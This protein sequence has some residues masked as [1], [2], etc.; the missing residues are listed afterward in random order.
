MWFP[1]FD[2]IAANAQPIK[3]MALI[4]ILSFCVAIHFR[5]LFVPICV[6]CR[7]L[8]LSCFCLF[9]LNPVR[10]SFSRNCGACNYLSGVIHNTFSLFTFHDRIITM[11]CSLPLFTCTG[12]YPVLVCLFYGVILIT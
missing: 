11:S 6:S 9:V 5:C 7:Y 2:V 8:F 4:L 3:I 12:S 10:V 1:I